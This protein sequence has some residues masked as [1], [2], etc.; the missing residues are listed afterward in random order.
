VTQTWG[1]SL[2]AG[3]GPFEVIDMCNAL[4]IEPIIT[5]AYDV[6]DKDDFADLVEYCW[7]D[8]VTTAWGRRRA[9]DGHPAVYNI[10]VV[11]LGNEQVCVRASA[12]AAG[13][14]GAGAAVGGEGR[15]RSA[16]R[17]CGQVVGRGAG[18]RNG[19]EAEARARAEE[20]LRVAGLAA[21]PSGERPPDLA[22]EPTPTP[23]AH[24]LTPHPLFIPSA[25]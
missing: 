16:A 21:G 14:G 12:A 19:G 6:N 13:G 1:S 7:G 5:L 23:R 9:A 11:E 17:W 20:V 4:D 10:T 8:A 22:Y 18:A 3:W 2:L 24:A 15:G 25:V